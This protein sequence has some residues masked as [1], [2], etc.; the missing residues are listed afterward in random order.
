M[1]LAGPWL[2]D[3]L[4]LKGILGTEGGHMVEVS[5]PVPD[6]KQQ[7]ALPDGVP[8]LQ[9]YRVVREKERV[10]A[11]VE[12]QMSADLTTLVFPRVPLSF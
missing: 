5:M 4:A 10:V 8:V 11:V 6:I 9:L 7:L 2:P 1:D 12:T 3:A